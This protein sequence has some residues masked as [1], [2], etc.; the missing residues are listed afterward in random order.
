MRQ[1]SDDFDVQAIGTFIIGSAYRRGLMSGY[2]DG[3]RV[4]CNDVQRADPGL[5]G[6]ESGSAIVAASSYI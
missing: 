1:K 5:H 3:K 4:E 6:G 2:L